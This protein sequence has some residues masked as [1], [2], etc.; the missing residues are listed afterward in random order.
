MEYQKWMD[1]ESYKYYEKF[2]NTFGF[3]IKEREEND[4]TDSNKQKE[5]LQTVSGTDKDCGSVK[6]TD[7]EGTG[8][9]CRNNVRKQ[10]P[11]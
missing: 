7:F 10:R 4:N 3:R 1:Y 11:K 6:Q 2:M 8:C 9:S 5:V